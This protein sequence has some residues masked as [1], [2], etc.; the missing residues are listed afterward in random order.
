M[1][2]ARDP[3]ADALAVFVQDTAGRRNWGTIG[4]AEILKKVR[5]DEAQWKPAPDT[6]SIWEEV[7]HI[8]HWSRFV[9]DRLE[10]RGKPTK[11]AWPAAHGGAA[12]WRLALAGTAAL[13][14][15]LVRRVASLDQDALT[16]KHAASR[17]AMAQ[18]IL[19]CVSHIAYHV[20]QITLLRRLYRHAGRPV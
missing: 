5:V 8:N 12:G 4:L 14:A 11:Q 16:A 17:Y 7:H 1:P 19:G 9:L 20:G 2:T 18:L 6:H 3:F 13:H 10:A 15:T